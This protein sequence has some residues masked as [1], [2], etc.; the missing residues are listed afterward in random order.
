MFEGIIASIGGAFVDKLFGGVLDIAKQVIN[1]QIT[2]IEAKAKVQALVIDAAKSVEISH[3]EVLAKTYESFQQSMR[4]SALLQA[5][6]VALFVTQTI[7]LVWHQLGIPALCYSL[8]TTNCYPSSGE[9][10]KWAYLLLMFMLGA[11][12]I[13]L[14]SGPGADGGIMSKIGAL[15][16]R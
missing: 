3:S 6:W 2:E 1:K 8:G 12:P 7:A 9:T 11:G 10:I 4:G 16:R 13:V 14:R 5:A 15:F